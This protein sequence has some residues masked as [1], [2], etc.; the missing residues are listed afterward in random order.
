MVMSDVGGHLQRGQRGSEF[1]CPGTRNCPET[2]INDY[3]GKG[4]LR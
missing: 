2:W 1:L 4:T 3:R